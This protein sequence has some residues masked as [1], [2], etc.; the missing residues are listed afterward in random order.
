MA[1]S[2]PALAWLREWLLL[3]LVTLY[4]AWCCFFHKTE[5]RF[6]FNLCTLVTIHH[7]W[8]ARVFILFYFFLGAL[9]CR[10]KSHQHTPPLHTTHSLGACQVPVTEICACRPHDHLAF[11]LASKWGRT[12]YHK[13]TC[14]SRRRDV[15]E[16][17]RMN[18]EAG[19]EIKEKVRWGFYRHMWKNPKQIVTY[20][21][22]VMHV[23]VSD[24]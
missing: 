19:R 1:T 21:R 14:Y 4:S 24:E 6:R 5:K 18:G 22:N 23:W 2:C 9:K 11:S 20:R 7:L 3:V 15:K 10:R 13:S 12:C 16:K 17:K 8:H